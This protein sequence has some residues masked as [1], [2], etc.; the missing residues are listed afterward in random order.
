MLTGCLAPAPPAEPEPE[1]ADYAQLAQADLAGRPGV[2]DLVLV[3]EPAADESTAD[4]LVTLSITMADDATTDEVVQI[5]EAALAFCNEHAVPGQ[6]TAAISFELIDTDPDD[7]MPAQDGS[8]FALYPEAVDARD[9]M[10]LRDAPGVQ[11]ASFAARPAFVT[12]AS[13]SDLPVVQELLSGSPL[14]QEGGT[15]WAEAGR[16]RLTEL[17]ESL[18]AAGY[19]AIIAASIAFAAAQFWLEAPTSGNGWPQLFVDQVTL[20][21]APQV[22]AALR[23]ATNAAPF[24]VNYVIR[25]IGPDGPVDTAGVLGKS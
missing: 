1:P 18:T 15:L 11:S 23:A 22:A 12:V 2:R 17:P 14:W 6:W 16:V 3:Q 25:A 9:F 20:D 10:A 21:E 13:A 24:D 8:G 7:D 19:E 4:D 5:A